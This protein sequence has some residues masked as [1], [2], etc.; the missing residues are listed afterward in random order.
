MLG[1]SAI[2]FLRTL[3]SL[4]W[5]AI[6]GQAVTVLVASDLLGLPLPLQPLWLGV[7]ALI[8]F[9][10]YASLR[11]RRTLDISY[12]TAFAHLLVDM[13]VLA[14]MVGWSGGLTNPFG[15]MFLVLIALAAFA[16]PRN[17]AF[18]A[19]LASLTG[20]TA[21]AVFGQPL[22]GTP[23]TYLLLLYG[24]GAN[25]L[26]SAAVVLY[27]S[28][29]LAS[30]LRVREREL[31]LLRE[32][33]TRNEGI[34]AL[35]THAAAMAHELNTPLATMTLLADEIAAEVEEPEVRADVETLRELLTLCR[36]RIRN[37]AVPTEVDLVRVVGQW[38]LVRPTIDL[39]RTGTLPP[40][41]RVEPAIA[42]LLQALLNNAADA[43]EQ[44]G[45]PR[46]DLHLEYRDGAL[47]GEV[48]DHGRGFDPDHTVLPA[49]TLFRS[50]KPD[51]LGVGLALS[52][53]TVEQLGGEMTITAA[54]GGGACIRFYLPLEGSGT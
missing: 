49:T 22:A 20:Y 54:E 17:W 18:A 23:N 27:F 46:I 1:S 25:F 33:F 47:S 37:L 36:E 38:R 43:G 41:L 16:L 51:G 2:S 10:I 32:R 9:N 30:D 50:G 24:L 3:C 15:T 35:A 14:W 7:G 34:V 13:V 19:A 12:G 8:T 5:L 6:A 31:A 29:R 44:A 53:A 21:A 45:D 26:I 42:H 48:R 28:T 4:R 11:L 52:H 39:R 40:S